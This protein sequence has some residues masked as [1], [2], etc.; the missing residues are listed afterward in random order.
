[1][2]RK[3]QCC[4]AIIPK[5]ICLYTLVGQKLS[6]H[7]LKYS[8]DCNLTPKPRWQSRYYYSHAAVGFIYLQPHR[9]I[10]KH[11][12]FDKEHTSFSRSMTKDV[13]SLLVRRIPSMLRKA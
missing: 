9:L 10:T 7:F 6:S 5:D 8:I 13:I 12:G 3:R 1:M 4:W 11:R 2:I